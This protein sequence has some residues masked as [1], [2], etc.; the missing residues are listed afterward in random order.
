[1]VDLRIIDENNFI[2][3]ISLKLTDEQKEFIASNSFSLAEAYAHRNNPVKYYPFGIYNNNKM[4]GFIMFEYNPFI[5]ND[6]DFDEPI[7]YISRMMIDINHQGKGYGKEA[8]EKALRFMKSYKQGDVEAI[9]LSCDK[10]NERAYKLY[11]SYGFKFTG[12]IDEDGDNYLR[13]SL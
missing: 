3:C 7:F 11:E 13:L 1:M 6:A 4:I 12:E 2:E 10:T 5:E 9:V 8:L